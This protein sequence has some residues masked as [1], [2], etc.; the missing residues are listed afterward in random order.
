ML[1][2]NCK[3]RQATIHL[4]S[5][6]NGSTV[7]HNLCQNCYKELMRK[8]GNP[9]NMNN[10]N[11][12]FNDPFDFSDFFRQSNGQFPNMNNFRQEGKTQQPNFGGGNNGGQIPP[13]GGGGSDKLL[14]QYGTNLT[15]LAKDGKIDPIIGRDH[16]IQR[17]IEILNRRR[18]NNPVLI[19]E[20]GVGKTAVVEGLALNVINSNVPTK[21]Q[22]KEI[23]Q[24]DMSSMV[25]GTGIRGQFEEKMQQLIDEVSSDDNVILF[26]DEIHEIVGAGSAEGSNMDA[27]N[28]LKP[29]LARGDLQLI[30]AT[31][32]K[33]YRAIEKDAALER[34]FQP[35][36][37]KEPSVEQTI[38]ILEGIRPRYED[39]HGIK[40][41]DDAIHAAVELSNRYIKD[42][43]LP[44]KAIDLID[45][46]GSKKNLTLKSIDV[47][48][49]KRK[50]LEAEQKKN[51]AT[52]K[53]NFE[54]AAFYRDQINT[55]G[56]MLNQEYQSD[57]SAEVTVEDITQII[58]QQTGIPV[59]DLQEQEQKQ[60]RNLAP[61]MKEEIIG[62]DEAIEKVTRA[63]QRSRVGLKRPEK[64]IGSFL[65][66]GPTGVGKTETARVLA[67]KLFGTRDAYIRLDMSEFMEKHSTS[68]LIGSPPG[69]VGYDEAGQLTEQV[70]H[71]PYSLILVDEVEKAHPDVLNIFLQIMDDGRLT[72]AQGRTVSFENTIIIMT[73]NAGSGSNESSVGFGAQ[74]EGRQNSIVDR[75]GEY[76]KPE[77]LNRFTAIVEFDSLTKESLL[78]IVDIMMNDVNALLDNQGINIQVDQ[79]AK[80]KI[81][82]LGYNPALGARPLRHVIEEHVEDKIAEYYLNHTNISQLYATIGE[83]GEIVVTEDDPNATPKQIATSGTKSIEANKDDE[84]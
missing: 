65:F 83:D 56:E 38:D 30:G 15:E 53:E 61:D 34:R 7:H 24:I 49:V 58:E 54:Q 4:Y 51:T 41:T 79:A 55:Y 46:S 25:Q 77:F 80:E 76:F 45:E 59:S 66:V 71:N 36:T 44:D 17:V 74:M 37:V 11:N 16:E 27:G 33:E 81:V 50:I 19:G 26:I 3:Q 5:D 13:N 82:D 84:D 2:E 14:D 70:R 9:D 48:D 35:V 23:Y 57:D 18:K 20:A 31:T 42:R 62:Q 1:C 69:Y 40:Y 75:L 60:L 12:N 22:N 8:G 72:D 28:I 68:K 10:N 73:S 63:I 32:L 64:P 78:T 43:Q 67:D 52:D 6:V 21:L 39:F 29:A 47:E